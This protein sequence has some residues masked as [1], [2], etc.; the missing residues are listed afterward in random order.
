M[1][2]T[3]T[4]TTILNALNIDVMLHRRDTS[5]NGILLMAILSNMLSQTRLLGLA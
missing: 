3:T 5:S 2:Q 4:K 1:E